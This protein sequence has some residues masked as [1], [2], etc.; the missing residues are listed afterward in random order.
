MKKDEEIKDEEAIDNEVETLDNT[1]VPDEEFEEASSARQDL[2]ED[3][4]ITPQEALKKLRQKLKDCQKEG[5]EYLDGWQRAKADYVNLLK[6]FSAERTLAE[7]TGTLQAIQEL[8]PV[9]KSLKR[10]ESAGKITDDFAGIKKQIETAFERLNVSEIKVT[11]GEKFNP[12]EHEALGRDKVGEKT[13]DDT[14]TAVLESGF[15]IGERVI[16]PVKVQVGVYEQ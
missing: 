11:L 13:A 1:S 8:L 7:E 6:R 9:L 16:A 12:A 4:E 14:I 2:A 10:A 5:R 15:K 3:E